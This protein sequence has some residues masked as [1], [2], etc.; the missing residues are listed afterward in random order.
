MAAILQVDPQTVPTLAAQQRLGLGC[1]L[2]RIEFPLAQ[3]QDLILENWQLPAELMPID[4][5]LP[6]VLRSTI[7]DWYIRFIKEPRA[8]Y[9]QR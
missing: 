6:R 5:G 7:R 1:D 8:V 9:S 4:F 3:P 2:D